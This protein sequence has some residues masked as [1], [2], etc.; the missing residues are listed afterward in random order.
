VINGRLSSS[1]NN[2]ETKP[3]HRFRT[4]Y[5]WPCEHTNV[6]QTEGDAKRH[7]EKSSEELWKVFK[8]VYFALQYRCEL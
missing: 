8:T 1:L 3:A 2:T 7:S 5:H 6:P 4:W